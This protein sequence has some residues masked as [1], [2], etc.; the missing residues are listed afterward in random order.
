MKL[1]KFFALYQLFFGF[2]GVVNIIV[3]VVNN[4]LFNVEFNIAIFIIL[5]L[6]LFLVSIV[7]GIELYRGNLKRG[8]TLFYLTMLFQ[9]VFF[10][11]QSGWV[12]SFY[13]GLYFSINFIGGFHLDFGV[14]S[15]MKLYMSSFVKSFS[16]GVNLIPI[17]LTYIF[18]KDVS[19][20]C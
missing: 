3:F 16:F 18:Y 15:I 4:K 1:N 2:I 10:Q 5:A 8:K 6:L 11:T 14:L 9:L 7:S 17:I 12:Y 13:N 19:K 20:V